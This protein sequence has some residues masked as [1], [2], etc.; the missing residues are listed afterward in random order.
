MWEIRMEEAL[1]IYF[2]N[3]VGYHIGATHTHYEPGF[4]L[5]P[6]NPP[7]LIY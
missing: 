2:V 4:L 6:A 7:Y 3:H 1:R 5:T